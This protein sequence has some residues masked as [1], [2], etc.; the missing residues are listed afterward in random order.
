MKKGKVLWVALLLGAL[1]L[2]TF[3]QVGLAR[4][5]AAPEGAVVNVL[6]ISAADCVIRSHG[7]R[8]LNEGY[9]L[10]GQH[11]MGWVRANCPVHFPEYGTHRV[12]R[13]TIYV[14]DEVGGGG[15]YDVFGTLYRTRPNTAGRAN[16]GTAKST[17]SS[18]TN[19]RAFTISGTAI[20]P[21][22]VSPTQG[23]YLLISLRG[24]NNLKFY[25]A[26]IRYIVVP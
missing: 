19:P 13:L 7:Q 6:T 17:G 15:D 9:Y 3:V 4:P 11:G 8:Y 10:Q 5:K 20:S 24:H 22:G 25:G 16:M 23:M 21:N 1:L 2:A 18:T 14:Y 26:Q 12:R